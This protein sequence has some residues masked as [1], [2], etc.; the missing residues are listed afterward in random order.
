MYLTS[1]NSTLWIGPNGTGR[2]S[3][4]NPGYYTSPTNRIKP[5]TNMLVWIPPS[6]FLSL[7]QEDALWVGRDN[8]AKTISRKG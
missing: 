2:H 3:I 1:F 4:D 8:T 5:G 6:S 7:S